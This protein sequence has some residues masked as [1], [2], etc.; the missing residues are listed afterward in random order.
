MFPLLGD[1]SNGGGM[2]RVIHLGRPPIRSDAH[3]FVSKHGDVCSQASPFTFQDSHQR[4]LPMHFI[5]LD[6]DVFKLVDHVAEVGLLHH[7]IRK[8]TKGNVV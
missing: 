3:V 4:T 1:E 7:L 6:L 2:I 5:V 8:H